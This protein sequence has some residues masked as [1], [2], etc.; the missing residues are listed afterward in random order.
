MTDA[1]LAAFLGIGKEDP[2][3]V[4]RVIASLTSQKRATYERMA[5]VERELQL[6]EQGLGPKPQGVMID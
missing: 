5:Q 4:A 2:E 1:E 6:Y 3:K